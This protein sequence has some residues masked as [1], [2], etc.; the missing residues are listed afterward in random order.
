MKNPELTKEEKRAVALCRRYAARSAVD[1]WVWLG[2][3]ILVFVSG[4]Y[5]DSKALLVAGF[6]LLVFVQIAGLRTPTRLWR[7]LTSVITKL[8]NACEGTETEVER[9]DRSAAG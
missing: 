7:P 4:L 5:S 6:G 8:E 9:S 2:P 3:A 1:S